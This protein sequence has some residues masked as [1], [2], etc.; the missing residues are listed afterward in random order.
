MKKLFFRL[1]RFC[2][3][4]VIP[5]VHFPGVKMSV[6]EAEKSISKVYEERELFNENEIQN[7]EI[8][9]KIDLS[10]IVPVYNSE[11]FLKRCMDSIVGQKTKYH[12]EIIAIND[13]STD[14]SLEILEEYEKKYNFFRNINQPNGGISKARNTGINNARGE[15]I[16][17]IDN[18]DYVVEEY[19]EKLLERAYQNKADMVKCNHVNFSGI[20]RKPNK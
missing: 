6:E 13:G 15:Y 18:D 2:L 4:L 10:I 11:K 19:V 14:G 8:D 3:K 16:G 20:H 17:F 5:T 12:F 9:E 1:I 7:L